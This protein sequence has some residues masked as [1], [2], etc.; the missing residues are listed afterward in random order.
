MIGNSSRFGGRIDTDQISRYT[1]D[2]QYHR[3]NSAQQDDT[4]LPFHSPYHG[5]LEPE[6]GHYRKE[7]A[8]MRLWR[9]YEDGIRKNTAPVFVCK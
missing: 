8:C 2:E 1:D 6:H 4:E 3:S 9:W 5:F 7:R